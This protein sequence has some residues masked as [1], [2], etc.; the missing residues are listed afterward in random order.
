MAL[1]LIAINKKYKNAG[2]DITEVAMPIVAPEKNCCDYY[3]SKCENERLRRYPKWDIARSTSA[4]DLIKAQDEVNKANNKLKA[5][6]EWYLEK[7]QNLD[8]QWNELEQKQVK[9]KKSFKAFNRFI[10]EN[11]EKKERAE[12][13]IADEM[14]THKVKDEEISSIQER[15]EKMLEVQESLKADGAKYKFYEVVLKYKT[16]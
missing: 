11:Q 14:H 9:L 10:R 1:N 4:F 15:I 5:K 8:K 7:L 6:Q 12:R 16:I 2:K 13:R 3:E